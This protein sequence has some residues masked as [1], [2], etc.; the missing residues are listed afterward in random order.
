MSCTGRLSTRMLSTRARIPCTQLSGRIGF[1]EVSFTGGSISAVG[2]ATRLASRIGTGSRD[3]PTGR[4][5]SAVDSHTF[6]IGTLDVR[7]VPFRS[8]PLAAGHHPHSP[9]SYFVVLSTEIQT[10]VFAPDD[11]FHRNKENFFYLPP[12]FSYILCLGNFPARWRGKPRRLRR[13]WNQVWKR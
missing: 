4:L 7:H 11:R 2:A 5:F 1:E 8:R 9:V 12:V 3:L 10:L 6:Q 13:F